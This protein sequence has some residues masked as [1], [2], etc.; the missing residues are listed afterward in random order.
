[1][2]YQPKFISKI[3][4][5]LICCAVPILSWTIPVNADDV[6]FEENVLEVVGTRI[7][8]IDAE[9]ASPISIINRESI[10]ASGET[11]IADLLRKTSVNT[12]GSRKSVSGGTQQGQANINLRGLGSARTLI[13]INGRR[14]ANSAA[15]SSSQNLNLIPLAAVERVEI[16]R[17]GAS[18]I[19]GSDAVG[20]VVN[21]VLRDDL[22]VHTV[23][24]QLGR[25]DEKGGDESFISL[26][27]GAVG[28]KSG[29]TYSI[30][31][32]EKD[33]IR[34]LDRD[35]TSTGFSKIGFPGSY[36]TRIPNPNPNGPTTLFSGMADDRCPAA[37]GESTEYPNSF[38]QDN[39]CQFNFAPFGDHIPSSENTGIVLAG[40]RTLEFGAEVFAQIAYSETVTE[41]ILP[42]TPS[43]GGTSFFP[44]MS[45]NNPNNPTQ[46]VN[47]WFGGSE[48]K[49]EIQYSK[50]SSSTEFETYGFDATLTTNLFD[51][52]YGS[53]EGAFGVDYKRQDYISRFNDSFTAS[54]LDGRAGGGSAAGDRDVFSIYGEINIPV[55]ENTELNLALRVDN[56]GCRSLCDL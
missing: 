34:N 48:Y 32:Q 29:M 13:L 1:M 26:T 43:I 50:N 15:T 41:G 40:N 37:L 27:G 24:A 55:L 42:P 44:T 52:K 16:L 51:T 23:T 19:Y 25:P 17:D 2:V 7:K 49:I 30:S 3:G 11:N 46:G 45:A 9:I 28:N 4:F 54:Q 22:N 21:I 18:S 53:A 38:S 31:R 10:E 33:N 6:N 36:I 12:F 47:K 8:R 20:G 14:I 5:S 35:F 56:Y 39:T